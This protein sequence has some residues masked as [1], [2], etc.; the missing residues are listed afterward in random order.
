MAKRKRDAPPSPPTTNLSGTSGLSN[1]PA[2]GGL[3]PPQNT[4]PSL[5]PPPSEMESKFYYYGLPTGPPLVA[6]TSTT[7]WEAPTDPEAYLEPKG[8]DVVGYTHPLREVWEDNLGPK[9]SALLDS[10]KVNWTSLDIVRIGIAGKYRNPVILWI[11][12]TP[13]SLSGSDGVVV[14]HK[15]RELLIEYNITDVD[16][17]I[18]E[19]VRWFF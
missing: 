3:F 10:M 2:T 11:G 4:S 5:P 6:R 18:R 16:V 1:S 7:P 19:S 8:L 9:V 17:E 13:A 15:C 12:V 14:A